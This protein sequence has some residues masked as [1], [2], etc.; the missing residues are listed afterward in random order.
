MSALVQRARVRVKHVFR[1]VLPHR[2][3]R[4]AHV[5]RAE[6]AEA[7][8]DRP[9]RHGEGAGAGRDGPLDERV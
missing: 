6:E 2:H 5:A 4:D 9:V 7:R 1:D 3:Q 8:L